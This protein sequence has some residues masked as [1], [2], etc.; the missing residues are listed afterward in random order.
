[1]SEVPVLETKVGWS[2]LHADPERITHGRRTLTLDEIEWV[3]YWVTQT[4]EKRFMYPTTHTTYW[5]FEAGKYPYKA[6]PTIRLSDSRGGVRDELPEWFTF[7][8]NLSAEYLEP[9]LLSDLVNPIY[10]GETVTIGGSIKV[11]QLGIGCKRPKLSLHWSSIRPPRVGN[12]MVWIYR[13]DSNEPILNVPLSHPNAN[14]I[15]A[16]FGVFMS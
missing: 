5:H 15:P 11:N 3:S 10:Q 6:A 8:A 1:M 2:A 12:G 4:T 14:L 16:L 13:T 9:R 7:M